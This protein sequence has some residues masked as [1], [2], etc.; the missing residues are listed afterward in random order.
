MPVL[1]DIDPAVYTNVPGFCSNDYLSITPNPQLNSDVLKALIPSKRSL[2]ST[3][4][5]LPN[6]NSPS[7][8]ETE[9]C[10]Q[11]HFN[12]PAAL[13]FTSGYEVNVA[14]VL[15]VCTPVEDIIVFDKPIHASVGDGI[16]AA[17]TRNTHPFSHNSVASFENC[18]AELLRNHPEILAGKST[19]FVTVESLYSMDGDFSPLPQIIETL[20]RYIPKAYSY[21]VVDE[22]HTTGLYGPTGRGYNEVDTALHT[23]G[24]ARGLTGAVILMSQIIQKY[25]V[26]YARHLIYTTSISHLHPIAI[27]SPL[28]FIS[29]LLMNTILKTHIIL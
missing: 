6:W 10:L 19:V 23:F 21:M 26:N 18:I 3:G 4:S 20:C 29:V 8:A 13:M 11:T 1:D 2:G 12:A 9:K 22:A 17:P 27:R 15:Q 5:R 16:A 25:L 14:R 7:H 28:K 24:K